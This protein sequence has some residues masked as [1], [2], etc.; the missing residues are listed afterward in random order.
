[1]AVKVQYPGIA[2]TMA[3]DLDNVSLLPGCSA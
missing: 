3:A 2:E 1:V